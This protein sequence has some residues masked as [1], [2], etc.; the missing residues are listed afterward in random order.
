M[1]RTA[2]LPSLS[3]ISQIAPFP[4]LFPPSRLQRVDRRLQ[5]V[6]A[7]ALA[8]SSRPSDPMYI[9]RA[10]CPSSAH[11]E[12]ATGSPASDSAESATTVVAAAEAEA[13]AAA[14]R[15]SKGAAACQVAGCMKAL[16]QPQNKAR[17]ML[18]PAGE[19]DGALASAVLAG[20]QSRAAAEQGLSRLAYRWPLPPLPPPI[21]RIASVQ[22]TTLPQ[23]SL[24]KAGRCASA[25]R[26]GREAQSDWGA[27]AQVVA[28]SIYSSG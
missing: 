15:H 25:S 22:P 26:C 12:R 13:P 7:R 18:R 17:P 5:Q 8:P 6:F 23:A 21:R 10:A 1:R 19:H 16:H 9:N 2:A 3:C 14:R 28:H 24:R 27:A 20:R 4:V 11:L